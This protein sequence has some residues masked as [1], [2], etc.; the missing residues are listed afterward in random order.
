MDGLSRAFVDYEVGSDLDVGDH[1]KR[2][3]GWGNR[4]TG[5]LIPLMGAAENAR[6]HFEDGVVT[7]EGT[8]PD[9][10]TAAKLQRLTTEVMEGPDSQG[11]EN[12]L[13]VAE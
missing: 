1:V 13:T 5:L 11:I 6:F 4:V 7:L 3:G 8:V 9:Q 12:K 2:V 10:A